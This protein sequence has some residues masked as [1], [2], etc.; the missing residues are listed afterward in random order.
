MNAAT[1]RTTVVALGA[2]TAHDAA[3]ALAD[4]ESV[5]PGPY[6]LTTSRRGLVERLAFDRGWQVW[7][8]PA[9]MVFSEP[10]DICLSFLASDLR[11]ARA[12]NVTVWTY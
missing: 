2:A 12:A 9:S 4:V 3:R 1:P 7:I 6:K 10:V 8:A 11:P 5:A